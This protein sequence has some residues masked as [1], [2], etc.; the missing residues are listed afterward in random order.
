MITHICHHFYFQL[1]LSAEPTFEVSSTTT[2][3]SLSWQNNDVTINTYQISLNGNEKFSGSGTEFKAGDSKVFPNL[4]PA[5]Q[6]LIVVDGTNA[7]DSRRTFYNEDVAT[8]KL[9]LSCIILFCYFLYFLQL[10]VPTLLI[11]YSVA[12]RRLSFCRKCHQKS[13]VGSPMT[14]IL[15]NLYIFIVK[16]ATICTN[17]SQM[18][19]K[20][21][22]GCPMTKI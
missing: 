12:G 2:S 1:C 3:I 10:P 6:Y 5:T 13:F 18:P 8:S 20:V 16:N 9:W 15:Q 19:P 4:T 7:D 14:T 21:I 22:W 11:S 17:L